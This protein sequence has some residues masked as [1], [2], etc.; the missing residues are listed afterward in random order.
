MGAR[1][2]VIALGL[3]LAFGCS[4][5]QN[6]IKQA[7]WLI[8]TWQHSESYQPDLYEKWERIDNNELAGSYFVVQEGESVTLE[9][10][11]LIE[12][13]DGVRFVP[14]M[15]SK[16]GMTVEYKAKE[17]SE[18]R[19]VVEHPYSDFPKT[20]CCCLLKG[21]AENLLRCYNPDGTIEKG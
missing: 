15:K 21:V 5:E 17:F 3:I 12:S 10:I 9:K 11:Q 4:S 16:D 1:R 2:I 6:K 8:G 7:D 18:N 19:I 14:R 13:P 20:I